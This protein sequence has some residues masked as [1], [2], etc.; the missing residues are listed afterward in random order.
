MSRERAEHIQALVEV[1]PAA[2]APKD[3]AP[4]IALA[5]NLGAILA[6]ASAGP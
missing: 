6:G 3:V 4:D 5:P 2:G 1:T